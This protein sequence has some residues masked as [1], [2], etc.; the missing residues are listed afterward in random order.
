MSRLFAL[1]Q[2]DK[3]RLGSPVI[4]RTADFHKLIHYKRNVIFRPSK[5]VR[6]E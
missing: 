1:V 2:R 6:L 3:R 4:R 5:T